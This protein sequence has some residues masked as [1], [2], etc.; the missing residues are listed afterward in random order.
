VGSTDMLL[1]DIRV[2]I[3]LGNDVVQ[4]AKMGRDVVL[5]PPPCS[6]IGARHPV[7]LARWRHRYLPIVESLAA[8]PP[9]PLTC[10]TRTPLTVDA[11]GL[12][13][14]DARAG[15]LLR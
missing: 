11:S 8:A 14:E 7:R 2:Q 10:M 3:Q 12:P 15:T 6:T 9:G 4:E 5:A 13:A 1:N